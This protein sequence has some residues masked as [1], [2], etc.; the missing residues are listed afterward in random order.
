[1]ALAHE[2][3]GAFDVDGLSEYLLGKEYLQQQKEVLAVLLKDPLF[4]KDGNYFMGRGERFRLSL[5]KAKRLAQLGR[6]LGWN[7]QQDRMADYLLDEA[8]PYGLHK[9]MFLTIL[10]DQGTDEQHALFLQKAENYEYIGCYA[11]T[12]LGHGSN[13]RGWRRRLP[14]TMHVVNS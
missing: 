13:V 14:M 10:R 9:S 1:M 4:N 3:K 12:E 7:Q 11:Q 2:R 6:E 8:T 5:A